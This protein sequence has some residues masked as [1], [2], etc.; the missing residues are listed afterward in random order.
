MV[1]NKDLHRTNFLT[2]LKEIYADPNLRT[3]L[4][5]KGGTAA[6]LFYELP[7]FSVDLD[8]DLLDP[9]KKE[10]VFE[11]IKAILQKL[12]VLSQAWGK[13]YTLFY[14]L[15]YQKRERTLKV[16][17]SKRPSRSEFE[18]KNYLGIPM[19]VMKQEDIT[20]GKLAALLT[21]REFASRDMFD[22]EFFLRNNW[23][24]N[25]QVLKEKTNLTLI[26]ALNE[27]IKQV[28]TVD[29]D[30]LLAGLGELLEDNKQKTWVKEKMKDELLFQ[31]RL[32]LSFE[33]KQ[34]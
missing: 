2:V 24:I 13:Q 33:Q 1:L 31:L 25:E 17:I 30:Q 11:K 7:R 22:L 4:G 9:T 8:F 32:R 5:F 20:A 34:L 16:E 12:G 29:K 21:R 28:E 3:V 6:M 10:L 15:H 23:T 27:A 19:L 14:L 26:E 18:L